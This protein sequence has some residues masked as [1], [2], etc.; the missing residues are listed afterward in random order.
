[1]SRKLTTAQ[2]RFTLLV[3]NL[4]GGSDPSRGPSGNPVHVRTAFTQQ[5]FPDVVRQGFGVGPGTQSPEEPGVRTR[6]WNLLDTNAGIPVAS[7]GTVTVANNDFSAGATLYL[8]SY[9][10]ISG[11]DFVVGG[12]A[13][14]TATNLA[15]AIDALPGFSAP[16]PAANVVSI[17][18]PM[19]LNGNDLL[20]EALY[21]GSIQ[22]YTLSPDDG[23]LDGAE[24]FAGPVEITP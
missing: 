17:D 22:N 8:G 1:M 3:A 18:G 15:A 14:A 16:A 13:N 2:P 20:F 10:L 7:S 9:T 4:R 23:S 24:P 6:H 19:G 5:H 11:E 21:G 12:S